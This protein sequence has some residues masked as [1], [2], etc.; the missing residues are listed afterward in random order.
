M[1]SAAECREH[2]VECRR[3][4]ERAPNAGVAA[5]LGDL[6]WTWTRLALEV[7]Q[8]SPQRPPVQCIVSRTVTPT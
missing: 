3:M 4:A 5:I 7:E 6:G 8:T 2:G 1:I